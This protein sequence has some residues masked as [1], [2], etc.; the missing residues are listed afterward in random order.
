MLGRDA[1]DA[2]GQLVSAVLSSKPLVEGIGAPVRVV[3][4]FS[5]GDS[6]GD[7]SVGQRKAVRRLFDRIIQ[8]AGVD[9]LVLSYDES[10]DGLE[11]FERVLSERLALGDRMTVVGVVPAD[12][13]GEVESVVADTVA[14]S[15]DAFA[16]TARATSFDGMSLNVY[17][18]G[19]GDETV[20][21]VPACGMPA[22][23][24]ESWVRFL[25]RDRRVLTW[26]TRGLF[27]AAGQ[28]DDFAVN[29]EAQA[30]DLLAVMDHYGVPSAH[31]VGLCG[32][33]V[34]AL[35]AAALRPAGVRS[36]S[37]W[38][39]SYG[40]GADGPMTK[41]EQGMVELMA[42]AARDRAAARAVHAAFCQ[43][44]LTNTPADVANLVLYPYASPESL[45]RYCRL[46]SSLATTDVGRY[47]AEVTQPALVVTSG[48]D[49]TAHPGASERVASGL[50]NGELL[51][52]E[53]G[54]HISVFR[55]DDTVL[56]TATDFMAQSAVR[57][58]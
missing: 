22:V 29:T 11:V 44:M 5:A 43:A 39:G 50:S 31:V 19:E 45:Y 20:V 55:A 35:A 46:N 47:L 41:H 48:D 13:L 40:F 53:H 38:H 4:F 49:H 18:A 58:V 2:I 52:R 33:A 26:E 16:R 27:G 23:L 51:M 25:A 15:F 14:N 42:T 12:R 6:C 1:K 57:S 54:D 30:A 36:L 34:I 21:L 8:R 17:D 24:T 9:G 32:G 3:P 56:R 7:W 10:F 37:L 28:P